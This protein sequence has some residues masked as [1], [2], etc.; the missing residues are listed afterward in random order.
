MSDYDPEPEPSLCSMMTF[1]CTDCQN[2]YDDP[3]PEP[4][5]VCNRY[6][7]SM[8]AQRSHCGDCGHHRNAHQLTEGQVVESAI[9]SSIRRGKP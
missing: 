8:T 4:I 7:L 9:L 3:E 2:D 5:P 6:Q 1:S